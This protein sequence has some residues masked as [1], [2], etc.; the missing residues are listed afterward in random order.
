LSQPCF[1]PLAQSEGIWRATSGRSNRANHHTNRLHQQGSDLL[2]PRPASPFICCNTSCSAT[3][4]HH[5]QKRRT[6]TQQQTSPHNPD[7][8]PYCGHFDTGGCRSIARVYTLALSGLYISTMQPRSE[9]NANDLSQKV[10]DNLAGHNHWLRFS[11]A[12]RRPRPLYLIRAEERNSLWRSTSSFLQDLRKSKIIL[13]AL[14]YTVLMPQIFL[15][16]GATAICTRCHVEIE[17]EVYQCRFHASFPD[18][19]CF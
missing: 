5:L 9:V 15:L 19:P 18:R 11:E 4:I 7:R 6:P 12:V 1:H 14:K 2:Q 17:L 8:G 16:L 10:A 3:D 13:V